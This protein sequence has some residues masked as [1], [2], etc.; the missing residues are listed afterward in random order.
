MYCER[1][2]S[3]CRVKL[4]TDAPPA[5]SCSGL[6]FLAAVRLQ[7]FGHP[8]TTLHALRG[9]RER[10]P[11]HLAYMHEASLYFSIL[12]H[13]GAEGGLGAGLSVAHGKSDENHAA[14]A[15]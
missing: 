8:C 5:K 3:V 2:G 11:G 9:N 14:K 1:L 7:T 15:V 12:Q 4:N 13:L 6:F 10:T